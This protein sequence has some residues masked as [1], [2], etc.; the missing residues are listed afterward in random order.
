MAFGLVAYQYGYRNEN[1]HLT[2]MML[3]MHDYL[4]VEIKR[5]LQTKD[6]RHVQM[7][8]YKNPNRQLFD[9]ASGKSLS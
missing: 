9:T 4:P 8:D 7:F 3:Q 5:T 1:I 2:N 6:F